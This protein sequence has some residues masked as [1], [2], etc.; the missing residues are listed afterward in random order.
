MKLQDIHIRDPF[1]L[2]ED[3]V[4]YMYGSRC[5]GTGYS[6]RGKGLD[7]YT[8]TD[9]ETW[10]D[11]HEC[12]T[13]PENFWSDRDFWAPE[14]HKWKGAYYMFVSFWSADANR[15]TQILRAESPMGP[16]LPISEGPVTPREWMCLDGTLY[17]DKNGAPWIVFCHEWVQIQNGTVCA[18]RLTDDLSAPI[19]EPIELFAAKD[20]AW[21]TSYSAENEG[22]VTDGPFLWRAANGKLHMLWSS[23]SAPGCYAQ[24][25]ATSESGGIAGPWIHAEEPLFAKDGGHGMLFRDKEGRLLLSLHRPNHSP[26]ERPCLI[27]VRETE[28]GFALV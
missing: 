18:L 24:A 16:F 8:S 17:V 4:Y 20:P 28:D 21:V 15:G 2:L 19:G 12:F 5:A 7:V 23:F 11:P 25:V 9:L 27:P 10:S 6:F 3:G 22:Y 14:V 26:M 1:V 13:R